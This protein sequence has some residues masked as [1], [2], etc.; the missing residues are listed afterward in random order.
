MAFMSHLDISVSALAAQRLRIEVIGHNVANA[1]NTRTA[2][3][4]AYRRQVVVFG[5]NRPF[6]NMT[7]GRNYV[8]NPNFSSI[9][10]MTLEQRRQRQMAGVQVMRIAEDPTPLTPVFDP[11]HPHADEQGYYYLPNVN[12]ATEQMDAMAATRA[13]EANLT[14][15]EEMKSMAQRALTIGR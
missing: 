9:L 7:P 15:F 3:G 8:T 1:T 14:I 4:E 10:E 6:K 11:T 2:S 5:E 13:Y 12:L